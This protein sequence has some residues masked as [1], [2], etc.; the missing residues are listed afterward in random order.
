VALGAAVPLPSAAPVLA[1]VLAVL[2]V[3]L[4]LLTP[5]NNAVVL[6]AMPADQRGLGGGLVNMARG[7][8]TSLGV[9]GVTLT[10]HL[11][12]SAHGAR[13]AFGMLAVVAVGVAVVSWIAG[14]RR[15]LAALSPTGRPS[16]DRPRRGSSGRR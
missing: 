8:G 14:S 10:L 3:G 11:A 16:A 9:A 12:G 7:L 1:G 2:G 4:G 5:A 13:W 6:A 15:P